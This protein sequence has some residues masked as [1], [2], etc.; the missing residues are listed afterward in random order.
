MSRRG[1]QAFLV[2]RDIR[3]IVRD[4]RWIIDLEVGELVVNV[5]IVRVRVRVVDDQ[6]GQVFL[7]KFG[8]EAEH[9]RV[10]FVDH[11]FTNLIHIIFTFVVS[12]WL[13]GI[14][15]VIMLLVKL[16]LLG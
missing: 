12:L 13:K 8:N 10:L 3:I 4:R 2:A 6:V 9:L 1:R 11:I 14:V 5:L 15:I 7:L 16:D